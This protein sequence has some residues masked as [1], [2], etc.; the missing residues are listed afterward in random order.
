[1]GVDKSIG[2]IEKGKIA[3]IV[4]LNKNPEQDLSNIKNINFIIKK[5]KVYAPDQI[6]LLIKHEDS[7]YNT[8]FEDLF[9]IDKKNKTILCD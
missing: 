4:V 8:Y 7:E 3:D 9:D 2:S 6:N 1:M 5:G